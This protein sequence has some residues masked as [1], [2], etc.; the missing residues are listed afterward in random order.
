MATKCILWLTVV[1]ITLV[2]SNKIEILSVHNTSAWKRTKCG[3]NGTDV[4][5][6]WGEQVDPADPSTLLP[7][8][9][10]PQLVRD[11]NDTYVNINGLWEFE[12]AENNASVLSPP[13][14]KTLSKQILVPFP[15]ESCLSGIGQNHQYLWYRFVFAIN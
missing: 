11:V 15:V 9:P 12:I 4:V 5:T 2:I 10:R 6:K 3:F 13:F 1:L 14:N 7:G 8:Y